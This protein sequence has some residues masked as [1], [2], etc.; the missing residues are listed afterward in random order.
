[1]GMAL[2]EWEGVALDA[3]GSGGGGGAIVQNTLE[4]VGSES[5]QNLSFRAFRI[6]EL[7]HTCKTV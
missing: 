2:E 5:V 4:K 7:A 1:M 6:Y 3:E